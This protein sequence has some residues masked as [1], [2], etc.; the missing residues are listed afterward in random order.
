LHAFATHAGAN[1]IGTGFSRNRDF[2]MVLRAGEYV[3]YGQQDVRD[4]VREL[5]GAGEVHVEL[6][7][8]LPL[9]EVWLAHEQ[10]ESGHTR[11]KIV[12]VVD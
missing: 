7:D 12:L 5:V 1:L 3:D 11:G 4:A 2:V 9:A 6:S 10:S 8:V